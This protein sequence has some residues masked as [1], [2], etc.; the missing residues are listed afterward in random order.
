MAPAFA[1]DPTPADAVAGVP[2]ARVFE[3]RTRSECVAV[4]REAKGRGLALAFAGGR[5]AIGLGAPPSRLDAVVVTTRLD[6]IVDH[7][8]ADQVV[9]VEAGLRLAALQGA[10]AGHGQRL[11]YDPPLAGRATL[12][13]LLAT[14]AF[15]PLRTRFGSLRDLL[16]GITIVRADGTVARGGGRVVKNVAGFDL[17]RLMIGAL[18][19]LG[20][21]ATATFRLHPA[22][23]RTATVRASG[24]SPQGIRE[25]VLRIGREHIDAAAV[26][27]ITGSGGWDLL[28]RFEG[29]AAGVTEQQDRAL[30]RLPGEPVALVDADAAAAWGE[31]D[32]A[33]SAGDVRFKVAFLPA[34]LAPVVSSVLPPLLGALLGARVVAYPTLGLLFVSGGAAEAPALSAGVTRARAALELAGGG[35]LVV[36]DLPDAA[37]PAVDVW[38]PLPPAFALMK[39]VKARFDPE[40]RLNPGRFVGGL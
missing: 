34:S 20:M 1:R 6:G 40:S 16:I 25:A 4:L 9:E 17:P 12:G 7:A 18:G 22:P 38:G 27:A 30:A 26:A 31:H 21:I 24:L 32:V 33:R 5:T 23:E 10:L 35:S 37:R 36:E 3:P 13:G 19:T 8:P 11:A 28:V 39:R 29:F 14:N 2:A 15:G